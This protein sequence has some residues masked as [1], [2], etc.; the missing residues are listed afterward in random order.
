MPKSIHFAPV[1]DMRG[2][3]TMRF[4]DVVAINLRPVIAERE[5][6]RE[7]RDDREPYYEQ[8]EDPDL[9]IDRQ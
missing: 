7:M 8:R 4:T 9:E 2:R 6:R 5:A 3:L 1:P